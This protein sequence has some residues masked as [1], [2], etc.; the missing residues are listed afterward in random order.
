MVR[1]ITSEKELSFEFDKGIN[2]AYIWEG[3][4]VRSER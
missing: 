1:H 2:N 4:G 3:S